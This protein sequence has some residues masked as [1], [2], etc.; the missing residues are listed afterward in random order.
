MDAERLIAGLRCGEV[1]ADLSDYLDGQLTAE[2]RAQIDA[3]LRGCAN[4]ERFGGEF[5]AAI[6]ALRRTLTEPQPL[7]QDVAARLRNRLRQDIE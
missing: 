5:S 3:H 7:E 1:L 4:C 6:A 2:R